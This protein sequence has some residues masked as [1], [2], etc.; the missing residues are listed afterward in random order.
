MNPAI[1]PIFPMSRWLDSSPSAGYEPNS[2]D[3][4][5]E[6]NLSC[7]SLN[8]SILPIKPFLADLPLVRRGA[9]AV[10]WRKKRQQKTEG[11]GREKDEDNIHRHTLSSCFVTLCQPLATASHYHCPLW[12]RDFI[13]KRGEKRRAR[14][15]IRVGKRRRVEERKEN[16]FWN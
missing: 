10:Q 9:A 6:Q 12:W 7:L 5:S 2:V 1:Y 15:E 4:G 3:I 16:K 8:W 14:E 13:M 11:G